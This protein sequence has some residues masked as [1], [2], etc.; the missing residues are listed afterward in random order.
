MTAPWQ[1]GPVRQRH[2]PPRHGRRRPAYTLAEMLVSAAAMGVLMT[3]IASA[4]LIATAAL[5]DGRS[6]AAQRLKSAAGI[7]QLRRDLDSA[8]KIDEQSATSSITITIPDRDGD[9]VDE[10]VRYVW[11]GTPGDPLTREY[12]SSAPVTIV[13]SVQ[14]FSFSWNQGN[15]VREIAT[16]PETYPVAESVSLVIRVG[17][18]SANRVDTAVL[19]S[20]RPELIVQ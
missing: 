14:V 1:H 6:P 10:T 4:V 18:D 8:L 9:T 3:G 16:G 12:N 19:L 13:E 5:D 17:T 15:G 7:D 2:I 11:T 20:N